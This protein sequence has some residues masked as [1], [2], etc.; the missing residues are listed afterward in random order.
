M[1]IVFRTCPFLRHSRSV[2]LAL[3]VFLAFSPL[4]AAADD[5]QR[6]EAGEADPVLNPEVIESFFSAYVAEHELNPDLIS[7]DYAYPAT[8]ERWQHNADSWYYSASLYKV[9]LMMLY[10]QRVGEGELSQDT[11]LFGMPLSRVEELVLIESNNDLAYSSLL[12]LGQPEATRAMFQTYSGLDEEDY[13]WDFYSLSYFSAEFMTDVML[14][15][16]QN[17]D[18]FPYVADCLKQAQPEH[19]FRLSLEDRD[20]EIAQKYG[21]YVDEDGREWNHA[22]G[23][24][25]TPNPFVLTVLTRCGGISE[26]VISDFAQWFYDYTLSL[27]DA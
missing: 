25:Y 4:A 22:A 23:I 27:D 20:V 11:E 19:Y 7:V 1:M 16:Y 15:L 6:V 2:L 21:Y 3:F 12:H 17:P 24:I 9:P 18:R 8:G 14:T 13:P 5:S 26:T 10:A